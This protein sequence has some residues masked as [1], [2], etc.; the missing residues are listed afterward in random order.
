M[1]TQAE[2]NEEN[3]ESIARQRESRSDRA[4][5]R[6]VKDRRKE[7]LS[8]A[9]STKERREIKSGIYDLDTQPRQEDNK[10]GTDERIQNNGIDRIDVD[11]EEEEEGGGGLPEGY[12]ET[13]VILCVNG[14]PVNGQI[15]FKEDTP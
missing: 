13:D 5:A 6:A 10:E 3:L 4:A 12:V 7:L 9:T 8:N 1:A 15:L 11:V 2:L 14:S